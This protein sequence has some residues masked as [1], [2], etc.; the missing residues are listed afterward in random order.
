[1][2]NKIIKNLGSSLGPQYVET[3]HKIRAT[4]QDADHVVLYSEDRYF[5]LTAL[6]AAFSTG[7]KVFLPHNKAENFISSIMQNNTLFLTDKTPLKNKQTSAQPLIDSKKTCLVFYTSGS[8]GKPKA[9]PKTLF[10]LET[11]IQC[12]ISTFNMSSSG[13]FISTVP[14]Y[15]IYGLLFSVLL[16]LYLEKKFLNQTLVLWDEIFTNLGQDDVLISSPSHLSRLEEKSLYK[17]SFVFSSSAPL[18]FEDAHK[19][20]DLLGTLPFEIYGSTETGGIAYRQQLDNSGKCTPFN[21]IKIKIGEN[22][23]LHIASPYLDTPYQTQDRVMIHSDNTFN[24]LGRHDRIVKVEGKRVCLLEIEQKL[25]LH[26][27]IQ[28]C[29]IL[30]ILME[31]RDILGAIITLTQDGV[32]HLNSVKR[33]QFINALKQHLRLYF[34]IVCI[35]RQ[36]KIESKMPENS[37]GKRSIS[38][39]QKIFEENK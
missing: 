35:P 32:M 28:D 15:H 18:S 12:L 4:I 19:T 27:S 29:V 25:A 21:Q 20:N 5:F 13:K 31:K 39:L 37:T 38:A 24:L 23:C 17:P 30:P 34:D 11:E 36:W 10:Q 33:H 2:I 9:I 14:H 3:F 22:N 1:M 7:G 6:L 8:T 16:P 26:P